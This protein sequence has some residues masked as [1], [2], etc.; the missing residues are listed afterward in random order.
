MMLNRRNQGAILVLALLFMAVFASVAASMA[1]LSQGNLRSA[2]AL[3]RSYLALAAAETGLRYAEDR[4]DVLTTDITTEKGLIDAE[5]AQQLW[6]Q[7]AVKIRDDMGGATHCQ[8]E[9]VVVES[10][11]NI[12]AITIGPIA[13]GDNDNAATFTLRFE[14]HPVAGE[15][16]DAAIYQAEPYNVGGGENDFTADGEPVAAANPITAQ[17]V[18]ITCVG[19]D[20]DMQRAVQMEYRIDKTVRFAIL[21][22]NRVMIGRNVIIKG[23]VGSRYILTDYLHGHPVQLRDNFHGL[24][25]D[26]DAALEDFVDELAASD[27]DGDNRLAVDND[28]ETANITDPAAM[29]R[30]NDGYIDAMDLFI[31]E[32]DVDGDGAVSSGEFSSG[33]DLVDEQLWRLLNE[34]KYPVGTEIDWVN[35]RVKGPNDTE[36]TDA[37]DDLGRIDLYDDYAKIHGRIVMKSTMW[38]WESGAADGPYQEYYRGSIAPDPLEAA[39]TFMADDSELARFPPEYFDV[40]QYRTMASGDFQSQV[41]APQANDPEQPAVHTPAGPET[42]ESVPYNSPYPYDY[43]ARPIYENMVFENVSIPKGTNALFLNCKFIGVTFVDTEINNDDPNFNY[44]GMQN[45]DGSYTYSNIVAE[46]EGE[47]VADTK[48][49]GNNIRFDSCQFEGVVVTESPT[50]YTHARNKLQFTGSTVFDIDAPSLTTEEKAL[51]ER[52]TIM[53]PQHS[54]DM[55]TFTDPTSDSEVT[56]LEGA[57][58]AGV[59]DVRGQATIDGAIITTFEPT[60][61]QAPLIEGG[62]PANFN[63]TIGYFE[64]S[65][66][67]SEAEIP[68]GGYGRILIRYDPSRPLPDGIIG[69]IEL[70]GNRQ[71]WQEVSP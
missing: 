49:L 60:P 50:T 41:D 4:V 35:L 69:P 15:D 22:R 8:D 19:V 57:I 30:N 10:E 24:T 2:D 56:H 17:W 67:D 1:L 31:A 64:S 48:P 27:M 34:A 46:V 51:F 45:A 37:A 65:A 70:R 52:S 62:N 40:T 3:E 20:G 71:T 16:Y 68:D 55:G 44:A 61:G 28:V 13:V 9:P 42:L 36:W 33:G 26:L 47:N 5:L 21:S 43:Y 7:I 23:A 12:T 14:P 63:T 32:F 6:Q 54:I 25:S 58:I 66:G 29:D 59:L 53:A 38:D 18:R 39:T 11:G